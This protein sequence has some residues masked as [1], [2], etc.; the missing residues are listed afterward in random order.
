MCLATTQLLA[1]PDRELPAVSAS[2]AAYS[3][4]SRWMLL[5]D[6]SE[7]PAPYPLSTALFPHP[8]LGESA[9]TRKP[10]A[11]ATAAPTTAGG[12]VRYWSVFT[13][14]WTSVH[15]LVLE[16]DTTVNDNRG[17]GR[18]GLHAPAKPLPP[19]P[20]GWS[21]WIWRRHAETASYPTPTDGD[22]Q[23]GERSVD[24]SHS[25]IATV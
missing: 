8:L 11:T 12:L 3:S 25:S 17:Y 23:Y 21:G 15:H 6:H 20:H 2:E 18:L 19:P 9:M 24:C 1:D 4:L 13:W 22:V 10:Q 5:A 7:M 16:L 14:S